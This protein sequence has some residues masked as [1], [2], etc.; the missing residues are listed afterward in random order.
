MTVTTDV[1]GEALITEI[2]GG[3]SVEDL[4]ALLEQALDGDPGADEA[5]AVA[6]IVVAELADARLSLARAQDELGTAVV[7]MRA[8]VADS[9]DGVDD[10]L[11]KVR[12]YLTERGQTPPGKVSSLVLLA[13]GPGGPPRPGGS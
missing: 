12:R 4:A 7:A 10:P 1:I 9:Q 6:A 8:A 2:P 13:W 5:A 3:R 11:A